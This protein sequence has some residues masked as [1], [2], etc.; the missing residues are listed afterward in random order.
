MEDVC[1]RSAICHNKQQVS[2]MMR[3]TLLLLI[4]TIIINYRY[5]QTTQSLST[6]PQNTSRISRCTQEQSADVVDFNNKRLGS[7]ISRKEILHS[8]VS[9]ILIPPIV[10]NAAETVGKDPDCN[11]GSC[12]GVW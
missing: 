12:L 1:H 10:T 4:N 2:T 5:F 3:T 9:S 8:I 7:F 11:D 6:S